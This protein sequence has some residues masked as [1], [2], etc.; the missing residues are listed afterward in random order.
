M[1][2]PPLPD[3]APVNLALQV[4]MA[5]KLLAVMANVTDKALAHNRMHPTEAASEKQK[6]QS[7]V[8][9][10]EALEQVLGSEAM[11]RTAA[12]LRE[13]VRRAA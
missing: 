11:V 13:P 2:L 9:T 1:S 8:R 10:L 5:R 12:D 4:K 6:C 7:I 3:Y